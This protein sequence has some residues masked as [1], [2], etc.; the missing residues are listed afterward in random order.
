[1]SL[2]SGS[3]LPDPSHVRSTSLAGTRKMEGMQSSIYSQTLYQIQQS[4][5]PGKT[6]ICRA[7]ERL[8]DHATSTDSGRPGERKCAD[9]HCYRA[10]Q[11]CQTP[12]KSKHNSSL[13][14]RGKLLAHLHHVLGNRGFRTLQTAPAAARSALLLPVSR[15]SR[16][17]RHLRLQR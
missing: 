4:S 10:S 1:M 17:R 5:R 16:G 11:G 2:W 14:G 7:P 3:R 13:A 8:P 12:C 9:L 6:D 15:L